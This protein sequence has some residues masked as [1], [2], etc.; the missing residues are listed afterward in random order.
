[1]KVFNDNSDTLLMLNLAL[2][3]K[4]GTNTSDF[5]SDDAITI[6]PNPSNGVLQISDEVKI[7]QILNT[8]GNQVNYKVEGNR[9]AVDHIGLM[10]VQL[11]TSNSLITRS[12]VN[13]SK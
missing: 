4:V 11:K 9:V 3:D 8:S 6:F 2:K 10:Y 7:I 1:M 5:S 13:C 12:V